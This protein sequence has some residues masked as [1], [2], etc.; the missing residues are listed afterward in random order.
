MPSQFDKRQA[1][2]QE[3]LVAKREKIRSKTEEPEK[4]RYT[5]S[6]FDIFSS[7]GGKTYQVA[8]IAYNPETG[9]AK[10]VNTFDISRLI[11]LQYTNQKNALNSLKT[12]KKQT[13]ENLNK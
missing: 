13:K 12:R 9:E 1:R 11:A 4:E 8:E 3:E 2:V 7:D 5:Q 10:L 6:G